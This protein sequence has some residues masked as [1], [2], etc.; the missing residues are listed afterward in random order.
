LT[1]YCATKIFCNYI[2]QALFIEHRNEVDVLAY[3]PGFVA[4][5]LIKELKTKADSETISAEYAADVCF[6]D[7]GISPI[8]AGALKH[9]WAKLAM[10]SIPESVISKEAMKKH[11]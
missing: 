2:A 6:R 1:L 5:K 10:S 11:K 8:S 4:T 9:E 7:L 3:T